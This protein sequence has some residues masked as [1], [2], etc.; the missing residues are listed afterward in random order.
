MLTDW[1][2]NLLSALYHLDTRNAKLCLNAETYVEYGELGHSNATLCQNV[3]KTPHFMTF[4]RGG[5][6]D[7]FLSKFALFSLQF[8]TCG[9]S[10]T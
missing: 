10:D 1:N 6:K 8:A 9:L 3:V 5:Q 4:S 7:C 2:N